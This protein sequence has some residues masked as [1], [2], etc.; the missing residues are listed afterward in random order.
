M[1]K[2]VTKADAEAV[3]DAEVQS[4]RLGD[5]AEVNAEPGGVAASM[6]T[7]ANLNQQN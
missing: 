1:D 5:A 2:A 7:A 3:Y 6:V 4:P